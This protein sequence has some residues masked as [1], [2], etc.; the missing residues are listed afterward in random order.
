LFLDSA[1]LSIGDGNYGIDNIR[2]A[3]L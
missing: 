3:K 2:L 1:F